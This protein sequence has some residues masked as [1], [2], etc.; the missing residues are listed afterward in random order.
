[1]FTGPAAT[2]VTGAEVCGVLPAAFDAVT[3]QVNARPLSV[4]VT[5]YVAPVAPEIAP[6]SRRH[7]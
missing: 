7:W 6:P 2:T 4:A 5:T 3:V 1:M